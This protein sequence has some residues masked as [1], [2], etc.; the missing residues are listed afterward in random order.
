MSSAREVGEAGEIEFKKDYAY[1]SLTQEYIFF[2]DKF[3]GKKIVLKKDIVDSILKRYSRFDG[4]ESTVNEI[5]SS[6][7]LSR[8]TVVFILRALGMTHDSLPLTSEELLEHEPE[9]L[10]ESLLAERNFTVNREYEKRNWK[11]VNEDA[12]KWRAFVLRELNPYEK[13]VNDFTYQHKAFKLNPKIKISEN[14]AF[15]SVQSDIHY[16]LTSLKDDIY[17]GSPYNIDRA[18]ELHRRYVDEFYREIQSRR[19]PPQ[20]LYV[21]QLGDITHSGNGRTE[22]GT[23]LENVMPMGEP[24]VNAGFYSLDYQ[25][26]YGLE[27]GHKRIEVII[28]PGNHWYFGDWAIGRMIQ[29]AYAKDERVRVHIATERWHAFKFLNSLFVCEHGASAFFKSLVPKG[30]SQRESYIQRV[31]LARPELLKDAKYK[32]FLTAD[33]HHLEYADSYGFEFIR[34]GTSI[35]GDKYADHHNLYNRPKQSIL[36]VGEKGVRALVNIHLD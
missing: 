2:T 32:Y 1:H 28:V 11:Q 25:I 12:R 26:Q 34:F 6:F 31:F 27:L 17:Y 15:M 9:E 30:G 4:D 36:E 13:F 24:Q 19:E 7:A 10:V 16:G 14:L 35:T 22:K 5:A 8:A 18:Q 3:L 21:I 23:P 33:Q 29:I 20:V